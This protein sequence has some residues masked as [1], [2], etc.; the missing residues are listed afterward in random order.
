MTHYKNKLQG[1][2]MDRTLENM[3]WSPGFALCYPELHKTFSLSPFLYLQYMD[4]H[5][6]ACILASSYIKLMG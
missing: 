4:N 5:T 2:A 1:G 6:Y 3:G